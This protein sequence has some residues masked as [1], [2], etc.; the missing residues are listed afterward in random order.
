MTNIWTIDTETTGFDPLTNSVV[1]FATVD[2][3]GD[4]HHSLIKPEH[5]ISFG[6]MAT[7]H[8]TE[9]MVAD[10]PT[11]ESVID[12]CCGPEDDIVFAAHNAAFD[13]AFL[14]KWMQ[15][16]PWICTYRLAMHLLPDAESHKNMSLAYEF[17][18][19]WSDM[20]AEAGVLAHRALYDAWVT[21]KLLEFLAKDRSVEELIYLST[22]P[23]LL[24]K[25]GFGKH[26]GELWSEVPQSYL[27]WITKQDFDGDVLHT[28]RHYMR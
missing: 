19:D 9:E 13:K 22:A 28:A 8:I 14:P 5:K 20:P 17:G 11:L 26:F 16:K 24:K 3:I 6:A 25:V 1:E 7:H 15:E 2:K 18:L 23:I 27:S 4:Y 12:Y 21:Q 10:A